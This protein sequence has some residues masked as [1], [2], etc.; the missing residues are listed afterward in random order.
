MPRGQ[1]LLTCL[2]EGGKVEE[3]EMIGIESKFFFLQ[4]PKPEG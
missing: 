4:G 1:N 3:S 2:N